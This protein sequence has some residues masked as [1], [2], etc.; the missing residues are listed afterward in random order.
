MTMISGGTVLGNV[1][2]RLTASR[3][4]WGDAW[5]DLAEAC[6]ELANYIEQLDT[7]LQ[8]EK[9]RNDQL[10]EMLD[11][12]NKTLAA[13]D[14]R[15][16]A[17]SKQRTSERL[18]SGSYIVHNEIADRYRNL[19]DQAL[20][21]LA[22]SFPGL[23]QQNEALVLNWLSRAFFDPSF[24]QLGANG[25][26]RRLL[27]KGVPV[28]W[29]RFDLV[30]LEASKIRQAAVESGHPH[31]WDFKYQQ[32]SLLDEARQEAYEGCSPDGPIKHVV[33]PGYVVEGK[34]PYVKQRVF[35]GPPALSAP[36][37][38]ASYL[39]ELPGPHPGEGNSG[40]GPLGGQPPG[41][42]PGLPAYQATGGAGEAT[43]GQGPAGGNPA[44]GDPPVPPGVKP[45]AGDP[46]NPGS[47]DVFHDQDRDEDD[48]QDLTGRARA[49]PCH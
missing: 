5:Q 48:P 28:P 4:N 41:Y 38:P 33:T 8:R 30:W 36:R 34:S 7:Q 35:T 21:H 44:A 45:Q 29:D 43:S 22:H 47:A 13:H 9:E 27:A 11:Q 1:R 20:V 14:A 19:R 31:T 18:T 40:Y 16:N 26:Y 49:M 46:D 15:L 32:G 39:S 37:T 6:Q 10:A 42:Q 25:S 2:R 3:K 24:T 23:T 17:L 12:A